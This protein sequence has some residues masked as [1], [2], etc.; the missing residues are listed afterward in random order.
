MSN[1]RVFL[2][3]SSLA[4]LIEKGRAGHQVRQGYFPDQPG[5]S[6][7]VQ[8]DEDTGRLILITPG[9]DGPAEDAASISCSQAEAL[10]DLSAGQV[11]SLVIPLTIGS[12]PATRHRFTTPGRIDLIAVAFEQTDR[13]RT[14]QPPPWFGP[15][16]SEDPAYQGRSMAFAGLPS[17]REMEITD[18]TLE[19]LLDTLD[20]GSEAPLPEPSAQVVLGPEPA[21]N[22]EPEEDGDDLEVEDSVIRELA[23]SLRPKRG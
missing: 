18:A 12:Q 3:A 21:S 20:D 5:R 13:A 19:S 4:R 1:T 7:S 2:V 23:R 11:N 8:V 17:G 10:L 22:A 16:V 6:I 15:E 9:P 14:Y